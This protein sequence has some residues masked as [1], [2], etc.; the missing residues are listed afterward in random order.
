MTGVVGPCRIKPFGGSRQ[1]SSFLAGTVGTIHVA[2]KIYVVTEPD[3]I[4][5]VYESWPDCETAVKGS[6]ELAI[7]A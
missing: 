7:N 6:P 5:G 4:R 3:S 1:A 2:M